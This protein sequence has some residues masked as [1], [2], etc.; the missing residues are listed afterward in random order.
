MNEYDGIPDHTLAKL[1]PGAEGAGGGSFAAQV[2]ACEVRP[3]ATD[4]D[5]QDAIS[6]PRLLL[7]RNS[8]PTAAALLGK[9][10]TDA[11]LVTSSA[12]APLRVF[13]EDIVVGRGSAGPDGPA[14]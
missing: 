8:N 3:M 4:R 2:Y 1:K 9:A 10:E 5:A 12:Q 7:L 11:R 6:Q 13:R 14:G